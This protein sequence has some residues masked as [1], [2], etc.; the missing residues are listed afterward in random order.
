MTP[1][2]AVGQEEVA[3]AVAVG[4]TLRSTPRG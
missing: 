1:A 3:M 4:A 2:A